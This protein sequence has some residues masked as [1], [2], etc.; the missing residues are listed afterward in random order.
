MLW[1]GSMAFQLGCDG[2]LLRHGRRSVVSL[3]VCHGPSSARGSLHTPFGGQF[4]HAL[5]M[6]LPRHDLAFWLIRGRVGGDMARDGRVVEYLD[7]G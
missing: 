3:V 5:S 2:L 6:F 7:H 4:P 1:D